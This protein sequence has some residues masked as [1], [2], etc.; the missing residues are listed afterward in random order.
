[1]LELDVQ[2][3]GETCPSLAIIPISSSDSTIRG[4]DF[5]AKT[6]TDLLYPPIHCSA[7]RHL[8]YRDNTNDYQFLLG[9]HFTSASLPQPTSLRLED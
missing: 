5:T 3:S 7:L 4:E 8:D 2:G 9:L 6:L 1:M